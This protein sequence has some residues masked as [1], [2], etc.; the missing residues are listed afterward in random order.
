MIKLQ[1]KVQADRERMS[2]IFKEAVND[3]V[4]AIAIK[5]YGG[6]NWK[7]VVLDQKSLNQQ[8]T[9]LLIGWSILK[10]SQHY[11]FLNPDECKY[12]KKPHADL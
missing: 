11:H 8:I 1:I 9:P 12:V 3:K 7:V 6:I 2:L 4:L 10:Y 5:K